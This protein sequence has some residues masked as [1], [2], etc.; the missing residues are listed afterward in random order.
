MFF[1][2]A[3]ILCLKGLVEASS[4]GTSKEELNTSLDHD[5]IVSPKKV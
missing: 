3:R 5:V 1:I 2:K 4:F